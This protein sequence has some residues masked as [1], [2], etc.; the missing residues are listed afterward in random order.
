MILLTLNILWILKHILLS[1]NKCSWAACIFSVSSVRLVG[2]RHEFE[3]RVEIEVDGV[4]GTVCD[5]EFDDIDAAVVCRSLLGDAWNGTAIAF[6]LARYGQGTGPIVMDNVDCQGHESSL[7]ECEYIG[8]DHQNCGHDEDVGV[9]C[10]E[11]KG[12]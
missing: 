12:M 8:I 4:L 2:G 5:D 11:M 1:G 9:S 6:N 3:G 7:L 10:T